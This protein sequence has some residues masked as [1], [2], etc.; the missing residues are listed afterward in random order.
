MNP[1]IFREYDI[2]G[3]AERDL[4]RE[5]VVTLGKAVGTYLGRRGRRKGRQD[6]PV[7]LSTV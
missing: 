1:E 6:S 5:A 4:K 7:L 2:R 3:I